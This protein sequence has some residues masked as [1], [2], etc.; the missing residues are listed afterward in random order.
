LT[1]ATVPITKRKASAEPEGSNP[2]RVNT[3]ENTDDPND[4][5][6]GKKKRLTR[7]GTSYNDFTTAP[8]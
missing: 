4:K 6:K 2:K 3:T 8:T 7:T 5:G 1:P